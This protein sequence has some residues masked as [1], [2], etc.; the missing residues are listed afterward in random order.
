MLW[1]DGCRQHWIGGSGEWLV[2]Q[3]WVDV[4]GPGNGPSGGLP[5]WR[6]G[7]G[8]WVEV[9]VVFVKCQRCVQ[10]LT[11]PYLCKLSGPDG[12]HMAHV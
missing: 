12:G 9:W 10:V 2:G 8:D 1:P 11:F 4:K 3:I 5:L 6:W 7:E